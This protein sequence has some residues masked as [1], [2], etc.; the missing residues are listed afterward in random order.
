MRAFADGY[1]GN[2][3]RMYKYLRVRYH[4]QRF[5]YSFEKKTARA[6]WH[7][8][9]DA[10]YFVYS[11]NNH[12]FPPIRPENM[13]LLSWLLEMA[14][15]AIWFAWWSICCIWIPPTLGADS[16]LCESLDEY[17]QR[18]MLPSHFVN[19]YLLPLLSSVATCSHKA[20]LQFPARD[21]TEYKRQTTGGQHYTA[22][23][24][25]EVQKKLGFGLEARFSTT[26][27]KIEVIPNAK[28]RVVWNT[29]GNATSEVSWSSFEIPKLSG[30][31]YIK[32]CFITCVRRPT[33]SESSWL[34]C[35]VSTWAVLVTSGRL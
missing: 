5:I 17:I 10:C 7:E 30:R 24:V 3:I 34:T 19:F 31:I 2:L 29:S 20:L 9:T 21:L 14:Y 4:P 18:M 1:Y 6:A 15:V 8:K 23:S 26:V 28:V 13:S 11:S 22:A 27:A 16:G 25:S 12:R 32:D 35:H 33:E